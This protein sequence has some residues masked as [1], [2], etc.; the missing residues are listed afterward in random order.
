MDYSN[1]ISLI[2]FF[3]NELNKNMSDRNRI[4]GQQKYQLEKYY[5]HCCVMYEHQGIKKEDLPDISNIS[6]REIKTNKDNFVILRG[7]FIDYLDEDFIKKYDFL[8]TIPVVI[9]I[10]HEENSTYIV[11]EDIYLYFIQNLIHINKRDNINKIDALRLQYISYVIKSI[12]KFFFNY[13]RRADT[14]KSVYI[15]NKDL[16]KRWHISFHYIAAILSIVNYIEETNNNSIVSFSDKLLMNFINFQTSVKYENLNDKNNKNFYTVLKY[17]N[18]K[19]KA[20]CENNIG[21][22]DCFTNFFEYIN[23]ANNKILSEE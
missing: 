7:F 18:P 1:S 23:E 3:S 17:I 2:Y 11:L 20:D 6:M 14:N 21:L 4:M 22:T 8:D 5:N 19:V 12:T 16:H 13:T 15:A 9:K 10:P